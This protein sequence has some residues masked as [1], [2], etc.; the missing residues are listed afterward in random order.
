MAKISAMRFWVL[1]FLSI[2]S[3]LKYVFFLFADY[4]VI[5]ICF[6]IDRFEAFFQII[7]FVK[8]SHMTQP[9]HIPA[10]I[11]SKNISYLAVDK[12]QEAY[13]RK[14]FNCP[15][16]PI[17]LSRRKPIGRFIVSHAR[18]SDKKPSAHG[19]AVILPETPNRKE[20]FWYFAKTDFFVITDYIESL[21]DIEIK[22]LYLE[23]K[24]LGFD[25]KT[26]I[27]AFIWQSGFEHSKMNY[28]TIRKRITRE[29]QQKRN[30]LKEFTRQNRF[31]SAVYDSDKKI[32]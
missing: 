12:F 21:I 9:N 23:S 20:R 11:S 24:F 17:F 27:D 18:A 15:T 30:L 31:K 14:I 8:N 28:E 22:S 32:Q 26:A 7:I 29:Q 19:I 13:L 25:M 3:Y 1:Y 6:Y 16:G 10:K 5:V 2:L 4:Q